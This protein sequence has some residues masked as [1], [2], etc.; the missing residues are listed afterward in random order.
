MAGTGRA[1]FDGDVG[2]V[3]SYPTSH[4]GQHTYAG[5]LINLLHEMYWGFRGVWCSPYV[6]PKGELWLLLL[7]AAAEAVV[8]AVSVSK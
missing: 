7:L 2:G 5:S 4:R 3:L 1:W 8:V 6:C